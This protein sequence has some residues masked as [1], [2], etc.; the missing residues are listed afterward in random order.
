MKRVHL[1]LLI[2]L[3]LIVFP[4]FSQVTYAATPGDVLA[5]VQLLQGELELIRAKT[6][7][8]KDTQAPVELSNALPREVFFQA[9][10]LF[11]SANR[12]SFEI[13]GDKADRPGTVPA[14]DIKPDHVLAV[15]DAALKQVVAAKNI[16]RISKASSEKAPQAGIKPT[17]VFGAI[18]QATRQLNQMVNRKFAP[19]DVFEQV[20]NATNYASRLISHF[21]DANLDIEGDPPVEG[22]K[23][24]DVFKRLS[25]GYGIIFEVDGL[26]KV[27]MVKLNTQKMVHPKITPSDVYGLAS[28]VLSEL[29][30]FHALIKARPPFKA[31]PLGRK[32]TPSDVFQQSGTLLK[33]LME[34]DKQVKTK[35]GWLTP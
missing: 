33:Y 7:K 14:S 9:L 3:Q 10:M 16:L 13:A 30:Y 24:V 21:P 28:L 12:L 17:A 35:P 19:S 15:V 8:P 6:G 25:D 20:T 29:V 18:I 32:I 26:S 1:V 2:A 34:L 4:G 5:R 22:K 11:D 27:Q 31:P 23:P